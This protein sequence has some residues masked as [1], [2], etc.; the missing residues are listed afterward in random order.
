MPARQR[1]KLERERAAARAARRVEKAE[2]RAIQ[3]EAQ[4]AET[5]LRQERLHTVRLQLTEETRRLIRGI[6]SGSKIDR[7]IA[8]DRIEGLKARE[9]LARR[10]IKDSAVMAVDINNPMAVQSLAAALGVTAHAVYGMY[11]S[12]KATGGRDVTFEDFEPDFEPGE[13]FDL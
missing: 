5:R 10:N 8:F 1:L 4:K 9:S 11:H 13:G 6:K 7:K 12:P 2:R 3:L